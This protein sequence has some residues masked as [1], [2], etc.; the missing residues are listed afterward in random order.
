M[1]RYGFDPPEPIEIVCPI[2]GQDC[3]RYYRNLYGEILGC[4]ECVEEVSAEDYLAERREEMEIEMG[5]HW[6]E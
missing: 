3:R 6:N 5:V 2:C 1:E 4:D